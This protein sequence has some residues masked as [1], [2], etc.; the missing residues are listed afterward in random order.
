MF[1]IAQLLVAM[2]AVMPALALP[3]TT[4]DDLSFSEF[5]VA[6]RDTCSTNDDCPGGACICRGGCHCISGPPRA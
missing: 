2:L 5:E 3:A 1:T 4:P 6:A